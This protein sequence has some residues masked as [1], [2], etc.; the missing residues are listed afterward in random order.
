MF[1]L[2]LV[3]AR[4]PRLVGRPFFAQYDPD[5]TWLTDLK[6]ALGAQELL[7]VPLD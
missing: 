5:A 4:D 7:P 2:G 3:L 6:P 1:G